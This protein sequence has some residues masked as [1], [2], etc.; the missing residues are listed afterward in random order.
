MVVRVN[1]HLSSD[2]HVQL[3]LRTRNHHRTAFSF[4]R[5]AYLFCHRLEKPTVE[6]NNI[7]LRY[8]TIMLLYLSTLNIDQPR[9]KFLVLPFDS[10][11]IC[12]V[13]NIL[14]LFRLNNWLH[15]ETDLNEDFPL[16]LHSDLHT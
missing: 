14:K 5:G 2:G 15:I 13:M 6:P 3:F 9:L 4:R 7:S 16:I 12:G 10:N 11:C 8:Y 1:K